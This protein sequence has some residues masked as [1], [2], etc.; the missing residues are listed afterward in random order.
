MFFLMSVCERESVLR[1]EVVRER[2]SESAGPL[3]ITNPDMVMNIPD[4][5]DCLGW[6]S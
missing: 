3:R 6:L 5:S 2:A 1:R 4:A